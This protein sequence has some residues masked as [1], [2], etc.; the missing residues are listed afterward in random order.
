[1]MTAASRVG[2]CIDNGP[3]GGYGNL[4]IGDVL[5]SQVYGLRPTDFKGD[6]GIHNLLQHKALPDQT[7]A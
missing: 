7:T 5:S 4:K 6:R 2:R 3:M 1:M